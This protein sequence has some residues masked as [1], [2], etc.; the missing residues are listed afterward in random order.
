MFVALDAGFNETTLLVLLLY[1][2][3]NGFSFVLCRLFNFGA[4][5]R[6]RRC[7]KNRRMFDL[8]ICLVFFENA[9]KYSNVGDK[10]YQG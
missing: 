10:C 8:P 1:Y 5:I 7:R 9:W 2:S 4:Q 6:E 3:A